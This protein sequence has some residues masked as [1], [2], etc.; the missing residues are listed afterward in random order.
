MELSE[1]LFWAR[2]SLSAYGDLKGDAERAARWGT[3][4]IGLLKK[5]EKAERYGLLTE[6]YLLEHDVTSALKSLAKV[7]SWG[8][9]SLSLSVARAAE[10][11]HPREAIRLYKEKIDALVGARGRENY[12]EAARLLGRVRGLYEGVGEREGWLEALGKVKNQQPRLPALLDE[13]KKAGL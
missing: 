3:L 12:A 13:L 11:S 2:P 10:M 1:T 4:H 9:S 8:S 6:I 7:H 5:L